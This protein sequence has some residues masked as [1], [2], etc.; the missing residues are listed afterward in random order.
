MARPKKE[1]ETPKCPLCGAE[2]L[3]EYS[4]N[5]ESF[6]GRASWHMDFKPRIVMCK[7]CSSELLQFVNQ[8]YKRRNKTGVYDKWSV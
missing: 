6:V 7:D 4:C 8:W 5:M 2:M 1:A 3:V